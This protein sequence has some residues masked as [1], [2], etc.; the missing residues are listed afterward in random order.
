MEIAFLIGRI[1]FGGFFLMSGFGH[2]FGM[3][4]MSSYAKAKGIPSPALAVF[5]TGLLLLGGGAGIILGVYTEIAL[6]LLLIFLVPVTFLM[7]QFWT[8]EDP[9][10]RQAEQVNFLKN[11]AL[12]GAV[13]MLF[14]IGVPWPYALA[15]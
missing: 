7:H 2:M 11:I 4:G 5:I 10:V 8:E 9:Q 6:V 3:K 14:M 13:L 12:T 15:F 1:L